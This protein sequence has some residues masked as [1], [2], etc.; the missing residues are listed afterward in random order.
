MK[1]VT[2]SEFTKLLGKPEGMTNKECLAL[3]VY[4][5]GKVCIS[6]WKISDEEKKKINETGVMWLWVMSG[7]T[8]PPVILTTDHPFEKEKVL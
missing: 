6:K 7:A 3:P 2:F 4:T 5:D 8:Q 1:G